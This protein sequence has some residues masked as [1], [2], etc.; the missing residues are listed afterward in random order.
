LVAKDEDAILTLMA[1]GSEVSLALKVK[2]AVNQEGV[3]VN[4]ASI[5]CFDLFIEQDKNYIDAIL[6]PQ[7]KKV[8]IEASRGMEWYRFA[9]EVIGMNGFGASAPAGELFKKFGF[10]VESIIKKIK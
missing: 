7:T 2:E 4:V 5:P 10:N 3:S 8:A 1:S 9:D 6:E